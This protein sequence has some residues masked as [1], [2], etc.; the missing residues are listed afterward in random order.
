MKKFF[1]TLLFCGMGILFAE[2]TTIYIGLKKEVPIEK[3][4]TNID[5]VTEDEI[6]NA[7]SKSVGE[8]LENKSGI[9]EVS[10]RGSVGS[11]SSIR[12]RGGGD[13]SKQTLVMVDGR[14]V[15]DN[16]LGLAD[17]SQ[18]P[19]EN[20]EKIE[21]LRGPSSA[22]YG[23]NALG[24]VVNIITRKSAVS[25]PKTEIGA[26][27]E[28]YHTRIYDFTMSATPGKVNIFLS[29]NR[30][31]AT[32][33]RENSN[34]A[35]TDLTSKIGYDFEK[36]GDL[37]LSNGVFDSKLGVPGTNSTPI[38]Q[39]DKHLERAASTPNAKQSDN[40]YYAQ[41]EHR[42][43]LKDKQLK[44]NIYWDYQKKNYK[45][46]D[47]FTN[48]TSRPENTGFNSQI[49]FSD[50]VAGVDF[51]NE[52]FKR[53]DNKEETVN[54]TRDN[55]AMFIQKTFD[56]K[57]LSL[58]PGIRY[59]YNSSYKGSTNPRILAVYNL[60]KK[61]KLSSNIGTA[62][63]APTFEDLFSPFASWPATIFGNEGN[64]M[65]NEDLKPEKS[66]GIDVGAEY[67]LSD[68]FVPKITFFYND[69]KDLI[70]WQNI[71][72]DPTIDTWRPVNVGKAFSR[73]IEFELE[74]EVTK[75]LKYNLNY[76]YLESMGKSSGKYKILQYTP[77]HRI[78]YTLNYLA[79]LKLK[80][81]LGV[82]YTHKQKWED[83]VK[84]ELPG[85]TLLNFRI[86]RPVLQSELFFSVENILNKRYV[87]RENFPLPGRTFIG[88][89]NLYLWD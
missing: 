79:P 21:V 73:G 85:Y 2:E 16:S 76:N 77:R 26:R 15:N 52:N 28:N 49:E 67:K 70:E 17:L 47:A 65:G 54:K 39:Y 34:Y 18:I 56:I 4:A 25:E 3:S 74:N 71:S 33:F 6:K 57:E 87:S 75:N 60:T 29:G 40:K 51:R 41:L 48:S 22:L 35:L 38:S 12:I 24:G 8:I 31:L 68:V 20:I 14:P 86:S 59:D 63:R 19:T 23:A 89:I 43:L 88:G 69:I 61:L 7:D 45:D 5:V 66:I 84:H 42:I 10:K 72:A 46:P 53:T 37:F 55:S 50:I 9:T 27:I 82:E 62:F 80:T 36:Y 78:N 83:F 44:T 32:G 58:T 30:S 1:L 64:T 81:K 13:S 11:E